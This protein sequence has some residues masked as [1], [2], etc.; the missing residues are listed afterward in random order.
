MTDRE[1]SKNKEVYIRFNIKLTKEEEYYFI[2]SCCTKA[3]NEAKD[4]YNEYMEEY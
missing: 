1:V 2:C 3:C 4:Q